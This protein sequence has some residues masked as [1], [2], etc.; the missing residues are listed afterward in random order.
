MRPIL[1][2]EHDATD[3]LFLTRFFEGTN[4]RNPVKKF[5]TAAPA[6]EYLAGEGPYCNR[7]LQPFP[8]LLFVNIESND[9]EGWKLLHWLQS[10]V[11][12]PVSVAILTRMNIREIKGAYLMGS[13]AFLFK[14]FNF[15]E[16]R[17]LLRQLPEI[18]LTRNENGFTLEPKVCFAEMKRAVDRELSQEPLLDNQQ[19][20]GVCGRW[21]SSSHEAEPAV[22][23]LKLHA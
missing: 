17:H 12:R 11:S 6:I 2:L 23:H 9:S 19:S 4:I 20:P 16:L 7:E 8:V 21:I 1:L 14:P 13:R 15:Q 3:V 10:R 5:A 22:Q 18:E